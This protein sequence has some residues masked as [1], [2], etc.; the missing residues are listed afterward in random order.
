[1]LRG[2]LG[3]VV[4]LRGD[5]IVG[6]LL[7]RA[8]ILSDTDGIVAVGERLALVGWGLVPAGTPPDTGHLNALF[9][10]QLGRYAPPGLAA[11]R[12]VLRP[13]PGVSPPVA[14]PPVAALSER[15]PIASAWNR[16]LVPAT[17]IV[18]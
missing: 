11:P 6:P 14:P 3:Q 8:L 18:A 10:Q 17:L 1:M 12:P 15:P 13:S 2:L 9:A 4:P 5:P 7:T 16:W